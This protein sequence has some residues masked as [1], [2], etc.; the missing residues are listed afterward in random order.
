MK[1][2]YLKGQYLVFILTIILINSCRKKEITIIEQ[3]NPPELNIQGAWKLINS[4]PSDESIEYLIIES[5]ATNYAFF[6]YQDKHGFRRKYANIYFATKNSIDFNND[7]GRN[8]YKRIKDTLIIGYNEE[9][10]LLI[11]TPNFSYETWTKEIA[12]PL[13]YYQL[14]EEYGSDSRTVSQDGDYLYFYLN[15]VLGKDKIYKYNT[16]TKMY[17]DSSA[18]S[19]DRMGCLFYNNQL[20]VGYQR[21]DKLK[22]LNSR[23]DEILLRPGELSSNKLNKV[24]A[25]SVNSKNNTFFGFSSSDKKLYSG[26]K[27]SDFTDYFDA[28][29]Y[30]INSI[31]HFSGDNFIV[32]KNGRIHKVKLPNFE[33]IESY[34][35]RHNIY[36]ISSL[37]GT[38]E[39][40][41][42]TY[43]PNQLYKI[44]L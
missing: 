10:Y 39:I 22:I 34:S 35:F 33:V 16:K 15:N 42:Y 8:P 2:R 24:T 29:P 20:F 43:Y 21:L 5:Q 9:K 27:G 31:V 37:P 41:L 40:L 11:D 38:K 17:T 7:L 19:G 13:S 36:G 6:L 32:L 14:P 30:S 26:T 18:N 28:N 4:D 1:S 3:H 12:V 23:L 25:L 44:S